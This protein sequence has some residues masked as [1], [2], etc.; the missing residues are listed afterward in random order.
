MKT[1]TFQVGQEVMRQDVRRNGRE[2]NRLM[3]RWT[4]P[5]R[6]I[7]MSERGVV[8]PKDMKGSKLKAAVNVSELK[9]FVRREVTLN[10]NA[11]LSSFSS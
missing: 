6:I 8:E 11:T 7:S 1:F 4:G 9:P 10:T 2:G 3:H 5:Y